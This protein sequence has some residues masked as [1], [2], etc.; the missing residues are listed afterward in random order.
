MQLRAA[1]VLDIVGR[2]GEAALAR[3]AA[4]VSSGAT[5]VLVFRRRSQIGSDEHR[6]HP[7]V[8]FEWFFYNR[9]VLS[10]QSPKENQRRNGSLD[11]YP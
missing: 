7:M 6:N 9:F 10:G 5:G 4:K 11:V 3:E 1:L 8:R 2:D